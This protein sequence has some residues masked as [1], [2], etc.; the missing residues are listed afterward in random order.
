M[1][2]VKRK[3]S[4]SS[5]ILHIQ[6]ST[7]QF[8]SLCDSYQDVQSNRGQEIQL[9]ILKICH[10]F[11]CIFISSSFNFLFV[12]WS[13]KSCREVTG[14]LAGAFLENQHPFLHSYGSRVV[15][16]KI[17]VL[18]QEFWEYIHASYSALSLLWIQMQVV[19]ELWP[20][21]YQPFKFTTE[22]PSKGT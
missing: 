16:R 3:T 13:T 12:A 8:F 11:P 18:V 6:T 20:D 19:L 17:S 14:M 10:Y 21:A 22:H 7:F 15:L 2:G 9:S 1:V 4:G 5:Y